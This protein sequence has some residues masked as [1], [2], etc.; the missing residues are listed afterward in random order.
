MPQSVLFLLHHRICPV[1]IF[2]NY[3]KNGTSC[4]LYFKGTCNN[5]VEYPLF[6]II[7]Y[8]IAAVNSRC[9]TE[10]VFPCNLENNSFSCDCSDTGDFHEC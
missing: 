10:K 9:V 7:V 4:F 5:V 1:I 3:I 2:L 6:P 8:V